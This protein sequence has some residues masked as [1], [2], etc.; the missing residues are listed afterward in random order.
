MSVVKSSKDKDQLLLDGFRYR[1]ANNSQVTWRCVRNNCAGRVTFDGTQYIK[2]TDQNHA[3]NPDEIIAAEFKS[4]ISERAI[5]FD[6]PPRRIINEALLNIHTDDG[7]TIPSYTSSQ[8]TIERNHKRN[9]IPLPRPTSF[10]DISIPAE[11][12]ITSS[13]DRFFII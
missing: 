6:D 8:R 2:L 10:G 7:T 5:T 13:G 12:R 3:P 1:R 11:L 9:G 4:K